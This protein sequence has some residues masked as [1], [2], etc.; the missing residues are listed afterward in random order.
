[1]KYILLIVLLVSA[2]ITAGCV[3]QNIGA[4]APPT[5]QIVYKTVLV[6]PSKTFNPALFSPPT[7]IPT[8]TPTPTP[9][10]TSP[11]LIIKPIIVSP[12]DPVR[13]IIYVTVIIVTPTPTHVWP[14]PPT[15]TPMHVWPIP[16]TPTPTPTP[17]PTPTQPTFFHPTMILP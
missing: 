13:P 5:P 9:A 11:T 7:P 10:P 16:P 15:P 6:T 17:I 12:L 2:V 1:M 4:A 8:P 14:I 3:T